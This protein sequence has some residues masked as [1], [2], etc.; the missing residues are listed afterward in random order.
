MS[1]DYSRLDPLI[2]ISGQKITS[3]ADWETYRREEIMV[4]LSNF[5]YGVRPMERPDD[6]SFSVDSITEN[7]L[8]YPLVRKCVRISFLG[9]DLPFDL[10][11]PQ[12]TYRKKPVPLFLHILNE[13]SMLQNLPVENPD[14]D[15]LPI[16]ALA[17]RGY[18][19][20]VMSTLAVAP[21]WTHRPEFKKG[22]FRAVQPNTAHRNDRSWATISGWAYGASRIMDYLETDS[23]VLHTR[24]GICG[25]SRAGKTALW[26]GATDL[27]IALVISNDSGC[28]GAAFTRGTTEGR[29]RVKNINV[30][31]WF[32][33]NYQKYSDREEMLP[34]D[35]H[36]LLAAI[37]P[38][39]LYVKSNA[40]DTWAGPEE[41]VLSCRLAS[42]VYELY[43]LK[44]LVADETI[45][46]GKP[47]H[48]GNIAYYRGF[49]G[50]N[51]SAEDWQRF[52]DFADGFWVKK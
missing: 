50:H 18:G 39:P 5:I 11:L 36:Y 28:S 45:E 35:Q 13:H 32:C 51:L 52:M 10:F 2:S 42:P 40:E 47:Y 15:F 16:T 43:G 23:D 20:A 8:G 21:D 38:R 29:E 46:V 1:M 30:S 9:Y 34:F 48:E 26:T 3:V 33:G 4:L 27:R 41:E 31:N 7:Y 12:Q 19:C 49:G 6:I 24:V 22:V 14:N 44:G 25:H 17:A 37:A